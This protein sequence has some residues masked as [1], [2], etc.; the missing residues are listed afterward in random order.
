MKSRP[1]SD[2]ISSH[3]TSAAAIATAFTV[4]FFTTSVRAEDIISISTPT[5]GTTVV[6]IDQPTVTKSVKEYPQV[7]FHPGDTV[8]V[9]AGGCVQ[10]GGV[11]STWK[12]YVNP[13]GRN[14]DHLYHGLIM[15]PGAT[16]G[17]VRVMKV[18]GTPL[19]VPPTVNLPGQLTLKLG[20]EDDGYGDNGYYSHDDGT[21]D[22]C[23]GVGNAWVSLT[24]KHGPPPPPNPEHPYDLTW[25]EADGNAFPLN[26][27]WTAQTPS[28]GVLPGQGL[29]GFAWL[30]PCTTQQPEI[31]VGRLCA[32]GQAVG[33]AG[34]LGGHANW[35]VATYEG[36]AAWDGHSPPPTDDDYNINLMRSDAAFYTADNADHVHTEFDSD[37]TI[38]HFSTPWWAAFH[39]AVDSGDAA[40]R[41]FVDG[42]DMVAMG[43]AGLDCAHS[44]GSEIHP[45]FAMAL[46]IEN[47]ASADGWAIFARNWGDE[48]FCGDKEL[49]I[50]VNSVTLT[51][52][53]RAGATGVKVRDASEFLTNDTTV[54][55]PIIT[56]LTGSAVNITFTLPPPEAGARVNGVLYLDWTGAPAAPPARAARVMRS[57]VSALALPEAVERQREPEGR[58]TALVTGMSPELQREY[59]A[60]TPPKN[61]TKDAVK[62]QPTVR[63]PQRP[64]N[65]RRGGGG[66]TVTP[67]PGRRGIEVTPR[68]PP[69]VATTGGAK[70]LPKVR[71]F[72]NPK[73][74]ALDQKRLEIL[75]R[76]Y[77]HLVASTH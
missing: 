58:I 6:R 72:P 44:C 43:V 55:G 27:R 74:A 70:Q 63:P 28:P 60:T 18:V 12:R 11:G 56:P 1:S 57:R 46:H 4:F 50:D 17:M 19:S 52:P 37:E 24:I 53:W 47:S 54:T 49:G 13:S 41:Q 42:K 69:R 10:T 20:Y 71:A 61:L 16:A 39:V 15:I 38:D 51:I 9:D 32:I 2:R 5:P 66:V 30:P 21:D 59:A 7:Q 68:L 34:E 29:C 65:T 33:Q 40:A 25:T 67:G 48:G 64:V 31:H 26:P 73:K 8:I 76:A 62:L 45:I 23:K 22:Q 3:R 75:Q 35:G 36:L 14:S 77:P